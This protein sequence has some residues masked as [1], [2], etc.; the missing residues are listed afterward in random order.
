MITQEDWMTLRALKPLKDAGCSYAAI[1]AEAGH[2]WR[3]VNISRPSSTSRR[4][5]VRGRRATSS[6]T[7]SPA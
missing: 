3:T 5:T 2:D 4:R 7:R 1:A 6:S